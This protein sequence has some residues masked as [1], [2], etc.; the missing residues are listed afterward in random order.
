MTTEI[1]QEYSRLCDEVETF[2]QQENAELRTG[3]SDGSDW[4]DN[5]RGMMAKFDHLL[6][7]LRRENMADADN[8][9]PIQTLRD[10]VMK[11][12]LK[13]LLLSRESEQLLLK[14]T[15]PQ[16]PMASRVAVSARALRSAYQPVA[17]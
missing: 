5:K 8:P 9:G 16:R 15:L 4:V 7:L 1:L 3:H 13:L 14:N 17:S 12:L 2:M 10:H 6:G 11:K